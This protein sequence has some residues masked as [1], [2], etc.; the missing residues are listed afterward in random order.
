M[1]ILI[2]TSFPIAAIFR[3]DKNHERAKAA[4][5]ETATE[6]I[7]PAPVLPELFYMLAT[8]E[9]YDAAVETFDILRSAQFRIEDLAVVDMARMSDIMAQ[10]RTSHFDFVDTAIMALS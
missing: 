1:A 4:L 5:R 2:D 3:R 9:H 6:R 8:Y 7:I 10:Y